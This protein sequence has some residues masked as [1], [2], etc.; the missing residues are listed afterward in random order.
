MKMP[1]KEDVSR[2]EPVIDRLPKRSW[3]APEIEEVDFTETQAGG[4][5]NGDGSGGFS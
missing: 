4:G 5:L 3:T 2:A 1:S